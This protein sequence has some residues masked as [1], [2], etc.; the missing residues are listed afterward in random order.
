MPE[1]GPFGE[2][3]FEAS[4]LAMVAALL[5][6]SPGGGNVETVLTPATHL[7]FLPGMLPPISGSRVVLLPQGL[8]R[9]RKNSRFVSGYAFRHTVSTVVPVPPLGAGLHCSDH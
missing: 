3:F 6:N 5:V 1:P 8:N 9:S 2:T 7:F 4:V